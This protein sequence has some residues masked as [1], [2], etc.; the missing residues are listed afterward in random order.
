MSKKAEPGPA[1]EIA[2]DSEPSSEVFLEFDTP[3]AELVYNLG[4]ADEYSDEQDQQ[5]AKL[6]KQC[7]SSA[8][9]LFR[10]GD[11]INCYL[12]MSEVINYI[13]MLDD[14][15]YLCDAL[16]IRRQLDKMTGGLKGRVAL[17][18]SLYSE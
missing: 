10:S 14:H 13:Q 4:V 18:S 1:F 6:L 7:L 15:T 8:D 5:T 11:Y 2:N 3:I 9:E 17:V 12:L 16:D